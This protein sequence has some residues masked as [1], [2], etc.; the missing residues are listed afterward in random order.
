MRV[1]HARIEAHLDAKNRLI[2]TAQYSFDGN[3]PSYGHSYAG[4][5]GSRQKTRDQAVMEFI[6]SLVNGQKPVPAP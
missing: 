6:F 2:V 3:A 1:T 4:P 5:S